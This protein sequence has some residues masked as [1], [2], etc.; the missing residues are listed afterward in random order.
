MRRDK[1]G[2]KWEAYGIL[3]QFVEDIDGIFSDDFLWV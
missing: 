3:P 1:N 2:G